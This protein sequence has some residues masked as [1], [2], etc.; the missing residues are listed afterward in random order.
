MGGCVAPP[1][2][3][4]RFVTLRR[5]SSTTLLR[6]AAAVL[7]LTAAITVVPAGPALANLERCSGPIAVTPDRQDTMRVCVLWNT[8]DVV[9]FI[10]Y[11][12]SP[13]IGPERYGEYDFSIQV[14][15]GNVAY[16]LTWFGADRPP[17][18]TFFRPSFDVYGYS[19]PNEPGNQTFFVRAT[20]A[21]NSQ[22]STAV[23]GQSPSI[24]A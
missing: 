1:T 13:I 8:T 6:G 15:R 4:G 10:R 23:S 12:P 11:Y 17:Y 20:V 21:V 2:G 5:W 24:T 14:Y 3:Y 18:L 7:A 22:Q 16:G 19:L 9:G